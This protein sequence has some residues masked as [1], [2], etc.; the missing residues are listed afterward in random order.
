[1]D[2][3]ETATADVAAARVNDGLGIAYSHRGIDRITSLAEDAGANACRQS[4]LRDHHPTLRRG[5]C[6]T[7][8]DRK[9]A[10]DEQAT[11]LRMPEY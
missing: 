11:Q 5:R 10:Y 7:R 4:L 1:V 8:Y 2:Q 9:N 6:A 3:H